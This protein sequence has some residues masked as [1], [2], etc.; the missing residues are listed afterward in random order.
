VFSH[1]DIA[2]ERKEGLNFSK[3]Q[4]SETGFKIVLIYMYQKNE[5]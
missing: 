3:M 2:L 4:A 5:K 1:T